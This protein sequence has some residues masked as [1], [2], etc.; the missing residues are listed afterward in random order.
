MLHDML[1]PMCLHSHAG[2]GPARSVVAASSGKIHCG[3]SLCLRASND[4][5]VFC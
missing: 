1:E 5:G 2:Y 3:W 4:C